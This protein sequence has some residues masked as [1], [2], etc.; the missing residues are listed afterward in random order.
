MPDHITP[1]PDT[2]DL[3]LNAPAV[4]AVLSGPDHVYEFANNHYMNAV[5][6]RDI[7]GKPIR[8]ALPELEGQVI[9][10]LLDNVYRT[11]IPY[12]GSELKLMLDTKGKGELEEIYFNFIYQPVHNNA[13]KVEKIFV[14][15]SDVT[16]LVK[17]RQ[18]VEE[19]EKKF[20]TLVMEA[21]MATGLYTGREMRVELAND[22]MLKLWGK[23]HTVI[24]KTLREALPELEGQ[25]FHQL[26]EDVFTTGKAY[27]SEEQSADLVVDGKL[28]TFWFNFTY[29]PIHNAHGEVYAILNMAVDITSQVE[30]KKK[31]RDAMSQVQFIIDAAEFGTWNSDRVN[32]VVT[33][34][35]RCREIL[36]FDKNDPIDYLDIASYIHHDDVEKVRTAMSNA[37][38]RESNGHYEV[39]FRTLGRQN[40]A[41]RWVRSKGKVDFDNKGEPIRF[42]G[43]VQDF[44]EY[45]KLQQQKDDFLAIASHELKTPVT[46]VKAYAQMM[47]SIFRGRG[48]EREAVMLSKMDRQ[49]DKLSNLVNDL[50]DVTKI[51]AGK[52][53]FNEDRYELATLTEEVIEE[54]ER[55]TQTHSIIREITGPVSMYGDK[56]RVA[57][58]MIN[59]ITNAIKYSPGAH[60]VIVSTRYENGRAVFSVKDFGMGIPKDKQDMVFEQFYRITHKSPKIQGLGLGL[61]IS[62]QII[63]R[64]GGKIW[65]ESEEGQGS[66]FSFML[67]VGK[68]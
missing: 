46:S 28:Q 50:L 42:A 65:V 19:N 32:N 47:E 8:E 22:M 14:H 13:G 48:D 31:M 36:G 61:Y 6:K 66:T 15:A 3:L 16:D 54:I 1:T 57:Q 23:D 5:G 18:K 51:N 12:Y 20:R 30:A 38:T 34:D 62:S 26:L 4:I 68:G 64:Q 11:G 25:P 52:L 45:R 41:M 40:R 17:A 39:E 37:S 44:T 53:Q 2:M 10:E 58:V 33:W 60:K 29:K 7:I 9:F 67:P 21:P 35:D 59:L 27:H 56:D 63:R 49:V 55:T 24:G 43:I